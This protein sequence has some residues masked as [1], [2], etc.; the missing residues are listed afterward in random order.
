[1]T[2]GKLI[3]V[4]PSE[5]MR[6]T[7]K[8]TIK[9][10]PS[11]FLDGR[12]VDVVPG[13]FDDFSAVSKFGIE[14]GQVDGVLIAQAFHWCTDF[15]AALVS[16]AHLGNALLMIRRCSPLCHYDTPFYLTHRAFYTRNAIA[17]DRFLSLPRLP[18]DPHLEYRGPLHDLV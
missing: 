4:E 12:T 13:S 18:S 8:K 11:T 16:P 7:W 6:E 17:R 5:A 3:G 2:L 15:D 9:S 10:L 14:E 1:M